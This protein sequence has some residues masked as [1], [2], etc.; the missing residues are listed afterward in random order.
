MASKTSVLLDNI[1]KILN[2][3]ISDQSVSQDYTLAQIFDFLCPNNPSAKY[4]LAKIYY[5][6]EFYSQAENYSNQALSLLENIENK[7]KYD[8]TSMSDMYYCKAK[9]L[10][11]QKKNKEL[12]ALLSLL[13]SKGGQFSRT[14]AQIRKF[15][16]ELFK[17]YVNIQ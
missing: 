13:E 10:Y 5:F 2:E 16:L 4:F 17:R 12:Q 7:T 15:D 3:K 8:Y 14:S 9:S 6:L 1:S 11:L